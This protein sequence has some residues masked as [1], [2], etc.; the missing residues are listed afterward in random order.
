MIDRKKIFYLKLLIVFCMLAISC[1]S[2][3][4]AM[5]EA[6]LVFRNGAVYTVDKKRTWAEAVAI[7][8]GKIIFVGENGGVEKF[9]A[10]GAMVIDLGGKMLLPGFHD[11]HAHVLEGGYALSMCT[12]E[13]F[14][15]KEE[16]LLKIGK[17]AEA[18]PKN[19]WITGFGWALEAFPHGNALKEDLDKIIPDRPVFML[20]DDGHSAWV[21][22]LALKKAGITKDTPDP[23]DGRIERNEKGEPGGTLR[24]GAMELVQ[25]IAI[26]PG[27]F[28]AIRSLR[29]GI[30]EANKYGITSYVEAR[31]NIDEHYDWL[32][33]LTHVLGKFNARVSM[34]LL[35]DPKGDDA[36]IKRLTNRYQSGKGTLL[37]ADQIKIFIDGVTEARTAAVF[38]H[39]AGEPENF[40]ILNFET[41]KL[42]KWA[43][44]L[45][46][47]G[48][49]LHMHAVGDKAVHEGLNIIQAVQTANTRQDAR[50]QIVHLYLVSEN[51]RPRFKEL[52]VIANFQA[53]WAYPG[54]FNYRMNRQYLG[55]ERYRQLFP[56][57][58]VLNA[59]AFMVGGSDWPVSRISPLTAIQTAITRQDPL[60]GE[61]SRTLNKE[62]CIDLATMIEA[63]TINGAYLQHQE[64]ITGSI[65]KGKFADLIVIDRNLFK[66]PVYDISKAKVLLTLLGGK[67]VYQSTW[68]KQRLEP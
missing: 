32:Y 19:E 20:A 3:T 12:L 68:A 7:E 59:G 47:A 9:I 42:K 22:S 15:T 60:K 33:R 25:D 18:N 43:V 57:K 30:A 55:E 41:E 24:D 1:K 17:Y 40:G 4:L 44:E 37:K 31:V 16:Y 5:P 10:Q 13:N 52:D 27:L 34:S 45:D 53:T 35:L 49:Q 50:H 36:Q 54:D 56:I 61:N 2:F 26:D 46:K 51:D 28:E 38:E 29:N 8:K 66:I 11:S 62:E 64:D 63:Y 65:E 23:R 58:S 67:P 39:Y 14:S 48:F 6:D 21:N